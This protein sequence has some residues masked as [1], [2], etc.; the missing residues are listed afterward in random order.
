MSGTRVIPRLLLAAAAGVVGVAGAS[1]DV[2]GIGDDCESNPA[3]AFTAMFTD[4]T[5]I[6]SIVP[7]GTVSGGEIRDRHQIEILADTSS[8]GA[9]AGRNVPV[10]AP[11]EAT[12]S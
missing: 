7:L 9:T 2:L 5:Q 12:R 6:Q 4:L 8:S 1:C 11:A 10:I 3:P